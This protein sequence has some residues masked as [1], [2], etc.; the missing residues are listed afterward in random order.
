MSFQHLYFKYYGTQITHDLRQL[1]I[2]TEQDTI[3]I[4][5]ISQLQV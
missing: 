2:F 5:C 3:Q 4:C 1:T